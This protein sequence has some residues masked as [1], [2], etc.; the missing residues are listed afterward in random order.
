MLQLPTLSPTATILLILAIAGV[1]SWG[2]TQMIKSAILWYERSHHDKWWFAP[3]IRGI[4]LLVGAGTGYLLLPG[5]VGAGVGAAG[6]VLNST[7]VMIIKS[8]LKAL[9]PSIG[10]QPDPTGAPVDATP[11]APPSGS[12]QT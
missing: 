6:G 3:L 2:I 7:I 4:A 9:D 12:A 1:V 10:A 8:K 5:V 11:V